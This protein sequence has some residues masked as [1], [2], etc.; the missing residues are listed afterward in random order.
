MLFKKGVAL[1]GRRTD[2][3]PLHYAKR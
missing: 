2:A 1:T 3:R